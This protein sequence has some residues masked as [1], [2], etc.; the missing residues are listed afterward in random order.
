[1]ATVNEAF[2]ASAE[3]IEFHD[4]LVAAYEQAAAAGHGAVR[5]R[6]VHI[7]KAHADTAREWLGTPVPP[8][9][10]RARPA[11]ADALGIDAPEGGH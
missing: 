2:T 5:Y 11:P 4:G 8:R 7:D 1:M 6:G 3:D 9:R 10:R